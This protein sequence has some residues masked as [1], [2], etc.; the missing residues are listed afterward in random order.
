MSVSNRI[1]QT[2]HLT[3]VWVRDMLGRK[4]EP[5]VPFMDRFVRPDSLCIHVGASDGRHALY[6]SRRVPQGVV[7]CIEPSPYT[8]GVLESLSKL[9]RV[10]NLRLHNFAVGAADGEVYLVTPIKKSGHRGRAFAFISPT[11]QEK[12]LRPSETR[13]IGFDNQ[14]LP[15]RS[16]DSFCAEK[17]L[18]GINFLRCDIEGAEMLLLRGG[19]ATIERD[20]PIIMMEI[21]PQFLR[22]RFDSSAEELWDWFAARK[23]T[24]FYLKDGR[25]VRAGHILDEPWRDYFCVPDEQLNGHGLAQA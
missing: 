15:L 18:K 8:L 4:Y 16:L 24:L 6:L 5:E 21:H 2:L 3:R 7:Y 20:R 1:R 19:A 12:A 23:Y 17:G 22:E 25:L 9:K 13:F 10:R 14:K 11:K